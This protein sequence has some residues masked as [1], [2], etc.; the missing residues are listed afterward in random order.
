MSRDKA[1]M[2][3]TLY[4]LWEKWDAKMKAAGLHYVITSVD[5]TIVQQ[6]ALFVQGRMGLSYVNIFRQLAGLYRIKEHNNKI[7]TWTMTSK[8]VTNMYD[9]D[10]NN[11]YSRAFD[12]ALLK[13]KGIAHWDLKISVNDN[14]I[15]DYREA[16]ALAETVGLVWGGH[17]H[18]YCHCEVEI[19]GG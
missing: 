17:Y 13:G 9:D 5:R 3:P 18:D 16:G 8:H 4:K 7:V 1:Q 15:P 6:M 2:H 12:F 14:D 11:D 19:K 10:L